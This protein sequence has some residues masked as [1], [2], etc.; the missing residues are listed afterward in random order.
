MSYLIDTHCHLDVKHTPEQLP[1]I[2]ARAEEAGVG[3]LI[4]VGID[5]AGTERAIDAASRFDAIYVS[6][7]VH[8]HDSVKYTPDAGRRFRELAGHPK[9][10]AIG[11]TGL[12]FFRDYSPRENQLNAFVAQCEIACETG[13]P[14]VIHSRDA[15]QETWE[16]VKGFLP[17]GLKGVFHC[18]VYDIEYARRAIA[19]GF[20]I[21]LNG[22]LTYPKNV[23][24]RDMAGKLPLDRVVIETD[25]PFLL[26]QK[27]RHRDNEPAFLVETF[28]K[29]AEIFKADPT[30][31]KE[32]LRIN[33]ER[34]FPK[35]A[36]GK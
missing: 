27:Y 14:I 11:E 30:E 33:S 23:E 16:V 4:W 10:A 5:A 9:V 24:L 29:L 22:M 13:L 34:C 8:P 1:G 19:A 6:A 15:A 36:A 3:K 32:K 2:I 28:E 17:R 18:F 26:P 31:L 25:A 12:D 7:G 20:Y 35:L 21:A